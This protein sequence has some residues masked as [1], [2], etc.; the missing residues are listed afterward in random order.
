C[1]STRLGFNCC[2]NTKEV[3][4]SDDDGDWGIE[5]NQ[6]CGIIKS[7][8]CWSIALG[9]QCCSSCIDVAYTDS[10]GKWGVENNNWCGIPTNC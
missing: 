3:V 2:T 1:W 10:D 4:Y 9:Y 6:W 7:Y 8:P 5:N